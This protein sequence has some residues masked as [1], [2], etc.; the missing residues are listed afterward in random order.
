MGMTSV[1]GRQQRSQVRLAAATVS[2]GH[3]VA[4]AHA[5]AAADMGSD[6][7]SGKGVLADALSSSVRIAAACFLVLA[8]PMVHTWDDVVML[9]DL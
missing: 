8:G 5:A 1:F 4:A 7:L 6:S 2:L 9:S 3:I